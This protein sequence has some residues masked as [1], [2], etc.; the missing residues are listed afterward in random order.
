MN[1]LKTPKLLILF[2]LALSLIGFLDAT[3]L[4]IK[5]YLGIPIACSI[6]EGCEQVLASQFATI[7]PV[8]IAAIGAVY[9]LTIFLLTITFLEIKEKIIINLIAVLTIGGFLISLLLVWLQLFVIGAL[10]LF[11]I[12]SAITST[13]LFLLGQILLRLNKALV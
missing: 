8:P 9:Y 12:I 2:F 5:H 1:K 11:C 10:C 6:F 3:Y 7:G 13:L 4:A